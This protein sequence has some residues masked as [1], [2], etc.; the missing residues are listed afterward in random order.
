MDTYKLNQLNLYPKKGVEVENEKKNGKIISIAIISA[1]FFC[2]FSPL[3]WLRAYVAYL[4]TRLGPTMICCQTIGHMFLTY[5][6]R[7]VVFSNSSSMGQSNQVF[8]LFL[9]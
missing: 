9:N 2:I 6:N 7:K 5:L 8:F 4:T 3:L 1:T